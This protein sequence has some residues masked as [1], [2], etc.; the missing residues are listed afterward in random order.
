[1]KYKAKGFLILPIGLVFSSFERF[2]CFENHYFLQ[3][4]SKTNFKKNVFAKK[5]F[6]KVSLT[7]NSSC[8]KKISQSSFYFQK[9][10]IL[11]GAKPMLMITWTERINCFHEYGIL[12][13]GVLMFSVSNF[14]ILRFSA[15]N[16]K[17]RPIGYC[18]IKRTGHR[19]GVLD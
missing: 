5:P 9:S 10:F 11:L 12:F 17:D 8:N 15:C 3:K 7:E 13:K 2:Y 4:T 6:F 19:R 1:M 18:C 14:I 16:V